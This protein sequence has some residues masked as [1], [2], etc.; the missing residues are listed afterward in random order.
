VLTRWTPVKNLTFSGEVQWFHLDQNMSGSATF[1][2]T[3]PKPTAL[4]EF[5]DQNAVSLQV[6][7]Q[8]NF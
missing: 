8:R 3:S 4:Y 2:A 1:A 6:R 7:A 5:K